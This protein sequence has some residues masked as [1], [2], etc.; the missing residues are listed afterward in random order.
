MPFSWR[1]AL[2]PG[3]ALT[4]SHAAYVLCTAEDSDW[5][6]SD[7][8][9]QL[10]AGVRA[11]VDALCGA[12]PM[13][14]PPDPARPRGD[15]R[16]EDEP[17]PPARPV[18]I[19]T[20]YA[21]VRAAVTTAAVRFVAGPQEAA[22]LF[23][24]R[25]VTDFLALPPAQRVAQFPYEG[26]FVRKDLLPLTVRRCCFGEPGVPA[27]APAWW[28][29]CY[30]LTTEFH[31]FAEEH[32]RREEAGEP[33]TWIIKPAQGTRAHGHTFAARL[34]DCAKAAPI[35]SDKVAQL[36]VR[37][38]LTARGRKFDMRWFVLVRS[39]VP[40]EAYAHQLAYARL[41][42]K[43]YDPQVLD[44]PLV[45]LTASCY[46]PDPAIAKAMS[47][48]LPARLAAEMAAEHP[49]VDWPA[50][51]RSIIA[52]LGHLFGALAPTVGRWPRSRAYYGCD[53][54]LEATG[55]QPQPRLLEVNFMAD[56]TAPKAGAE[57]AQDM[58]VY[59]QW[60]DDLITVLATDEDVSGHPRLT[61][62]TYPPD[63]VG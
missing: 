60:A 45:Q 38:P 26:G 33:N 1:E 21:E 13:V 19:H 43:P 23:L 25:H 54:I 35:G 44:D 7:E 39:F 4:A 5:G 36:L 47:R 63:P 59:H 8:A 28:L 31:L 61:R 24:T 3:A 32:R 27:T 9:Q 40:F 16:P 53:V 50:A 49:E 30:D 11:A 20:D 14:P 12:L 52:M 46:S 42:N 56:F 58:S 22:F 57:E 17:W 62:L 15:P 55:G 29:P 51:L 48:S 6:C 37:T 10:R 2:P 34:G 41:A 18:A